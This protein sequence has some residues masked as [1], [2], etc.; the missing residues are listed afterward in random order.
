LLR[1]LRRS[2]RRDRPP[3]STGSNA[4]VSER[5]AIVSACSTI[6]FCASLRARTLII[7]EP[8]TPS[9]SNP[10][11]THS[12]I[13]AVCPYLVP[14]VLMRDPSSTLDRLG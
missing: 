10:A 9:A 3:R 5:W 14:D 12:K 1:E 4:S 13:R 2:F 8:A 7:N 6:A 11:R